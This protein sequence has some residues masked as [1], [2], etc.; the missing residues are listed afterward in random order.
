MRSAI[1]YIPMRVGFLEMEGPNF[2][3]SLVEKI[4]EQHAE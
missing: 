1:Y 2:I 4:D 3:E